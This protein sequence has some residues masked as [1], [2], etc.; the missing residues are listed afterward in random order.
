[1]GKSNSGLP[2]FESGLIAS[3]WGMGRTQVGELTWESAA[4]CARYA[5]KKITGQKAFEHY[6]QVDKETGEILSTRQP[7]YITMSRRPGIAADWFEKY[8]GDVFPGD[9]IALPSGKCAAVPRYYSDRFEL[10]DPDTH[11][12]VKQSRKDRALARGEISSERL[13]VMEKCKTKS[14]QLLK[15]DFENG[16][17]SI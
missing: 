5:L 14:V 2:L 3:T 11:A 13:R 9:F 8:S 6:N 15:R 4:Y 10:V 7:E 1:M 16:A 17:S 12:Q